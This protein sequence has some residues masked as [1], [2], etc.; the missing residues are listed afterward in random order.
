M[1]VTYDD[2]IKKLK[3][4]EIP[5]EAIFMAGQPHKLAWGGWEILN[6]VYNNELEW[7]YEELN[8]DITEYARLCDKLNNSEGLVMFC[9]RSQLVNDKIKVGYVGSEE[10]ITSVELCG[11]LKQ[12]GKIGG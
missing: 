2:V 1:K 8:V 12:Y 11:G 3:E 9:S 5:F 10:F 6:S 4:K 7:H